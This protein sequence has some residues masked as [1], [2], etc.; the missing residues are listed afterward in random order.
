MVV[1]PWKRWDGQSLPAPPTAL[2]AT[3]P[4][5]GL[6]LGA[7]VFHQLPASWRSYPLDGTDGYPGVRVASCR[8]HGPAGVLPGSP[9][10]GVTRK[11]TWSLAAETCCRTCRVS[12]RQMG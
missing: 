5:R 12:L 10:E 3:S 2:V 8:E 11:V 4:R 9:G 7:Q 1:R 6:H